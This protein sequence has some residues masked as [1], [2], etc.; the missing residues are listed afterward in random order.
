[1]LGQVAPAQAVGT[2]RGQMG[3]P[4]KAPLPSWNAKG[5]E[6]QCVKAGPAPMAQLTWGLRAV[7]G[8]AMPRHSPW[9]H[10]RAGSMPGAYCTVLLC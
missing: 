8:W 4:A 9:H 2:E 10:S 1:M 6:E 7:P 5:R 3:L